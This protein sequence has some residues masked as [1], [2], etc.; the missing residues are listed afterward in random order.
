MT[1]K[2]RDFG[3][4]EV[5]EK[6]LITFS[7]PVIGFEKYTKYVMLIDDE[8]NG[9]AWLQSAEDEDICFVLVSDA[10]LDAKLNYNPTIGQDICDTIGGKVTEM[11]LV[12]AIP[13]NMEETT[14]NLKSPVVINMEKNLAAQAIA[15][16]KLPVRYELFSGKEI[17]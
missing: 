10:L 3:V 1:V 6:D 4:I 5:D 8:I 17:D 2:T 16:E 7:S 12:A 15:E 13:E 14:V 11:W 9:F